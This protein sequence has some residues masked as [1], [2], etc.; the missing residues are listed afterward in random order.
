[1]VFGNEKFLFRKISGYEDYIG[2][3]GYDLVDNGLFVVIIVIMGICDNDV[4][5]ILLN[6]CGYL[7]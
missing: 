3:C 2:L 7:F 5:I 6:D 4:G 1:M